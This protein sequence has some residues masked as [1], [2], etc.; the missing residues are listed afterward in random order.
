MASAAQ[1]SLRKNQS[2]LERYLLQAINGNQS[3]RLTRSN[4]IHLVLVFILSLW[5]Q[6][7][8][9]HNRLSNHSLFSRLSLGN[10]IPNLQTFPSSH[11]FQFDVDA[12]L[13]PLDISHLEPQHIILHSKSPII[14]QFQNKSLTSK[15]SS[16]DSTRYPAI[17]E[18]RQTTD[19]SLQETTSI[20]V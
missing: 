5:N 8:S 12:C 1:P 16:S 2:S 17:H 7:V 20:Q 14:L 10:A 13:T 18:S 9:N 11:S 19:S 6:F 3:L 15:E 4:I